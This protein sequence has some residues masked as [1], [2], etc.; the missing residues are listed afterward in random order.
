MK[1]KY[2]AGALILPFVIAAP[3]HAAEPGTS[4]Q[5]EYQ[6]VAQEWRASWP[7]WPALKPGHAMVTDH[8][9]H[10][11]TLTEYERMVRRLREGH[12]A[13]NHHDDQVATLD[14]HIVHNWLNESP[15]E[16][17]EGRKQVAKGD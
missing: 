15:A 2:L 5:S 9:G 3:A 11:H 8:K 4:C 16:T 12:D 7:N 17:G 6:T 14:F 10:R 1:H 13:C